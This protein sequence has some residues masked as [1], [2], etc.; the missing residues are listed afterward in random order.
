MS[1]RYAGLDSNEC[2]PSGKAV[3]RG[4]FRAVLTA[5]VEKMLQDT[6]YFKPT[7]DWFVTLSVRSGADPE[8]LTAFKA[9]GALTAIFMYHTRLPPEGLSPFLFLTFMNGG[10]RN[11]LN[12]ELIRLL[13]SKATVR[14]VESLLNLRPGDSLDGIRPLLAHWLDRQVCHM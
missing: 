6:T 5:A 1:Q 9:Y 8:R 14:T 13:A 3:G 4:V 12:P 10:S 7:S 2:Y 11:L